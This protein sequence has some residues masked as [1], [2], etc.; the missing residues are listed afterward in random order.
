MQRSFEMAI[1]PVLSSTDVDD[2]FIFVVIVENGEKPTN[3]LYIKKNTNPITPA[4][5]IYIRNFWRSAV[6][7]K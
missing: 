1:I 5:L 2:E 3:A 6:I 7:G 4:Y